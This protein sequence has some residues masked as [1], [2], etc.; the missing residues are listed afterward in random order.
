MAP[1]HRKIA[2]KS[3][4]SKFL[5][6]LSFLFLLLVSELLIFSLWLDNDMLSGRTGLPG[7]LREWG[8][9]S[10]QVSVAFGLLLIAMSW[11]AKKADILGIAEAGTGQFRPSALGLH[12]GALGLFALACNRLYQPSS[13]GAGEDLLV[14]C[15]LVS[16]LTALTLAILAFFPFPVLRRLGGATGSIWLPALGGSILVVSIRHST[17]SLWPV[18]TKTTLTLVRWMLQLYTHDIVFL[19]GRFRIGTSRFYV[20]IAPECSGLEGVALMLVFGTAWLVYFRRECRFPQALLLLPVGAVVAFLLNSVRITALILI[21]DAGAPGI[22][23]G[24]FHSQAGWLMFNLVA[25]GFVVATRSVRWISAHPAGPAVDIPAAGEEGRSNPVAPNPVAPWML[26]FLGILT[27]GMVS[28]AMTASFEW[29]Y[30]LRLVVAAT[31]IYYFR[32]TYR[33]AGKVWRPTWEGVAAG[34]AVFVAW[35][36]LD[37]SRG[38]SEAMPSALAA[39]SEAQRW[40]WII[41]RALAASVTVPIAEE[42]A[43]RGF[44]LRRIVSEDF[45]SVSLKRVSWIAIIVSSVAFGLLHGNRWFAASLAG[46]VY[47]GVQIRSGRIGNAILAHAITNALIAIAVVVLGQ[48]HLW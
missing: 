22:A 6:R 26:P 29:T 32:S 37:P 35:M 24:G 5:A 21:G 7:V 8:P 38:Q 33:D 4:V 28:T 1:C 45:E 12:F 42:L 31:L 30:P 9:R 19:P 10:V 34:V 41:C 3:P 46:A 15:W 36:A 14:V 2:P 40:G 11:V 47:A 16:G 44:L 27:A 25:I 20:G 39:A 48:W 43:F 23:V 17:Q 13:R 18:A